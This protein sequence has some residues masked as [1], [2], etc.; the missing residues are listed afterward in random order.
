MQRAAA[1]I[2]CMHEGDMHAATAT[3]REKEHVMLRAAAITAR[4]TQHVRG[5]FHVGQAEALLYYRSD[6]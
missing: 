5:C 1:Q 3:E 6:T 4:A 2:N